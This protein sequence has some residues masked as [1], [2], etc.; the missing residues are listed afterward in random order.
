MA[1]RVLFG[2]AITTFSKEDAMMNTT[3]TTT[4][5]TTP[6]RELRNP[7][8]RRLE[9]LLEPLTGELYRAARARSSSAADADDLLQETYLR[10]TRS[11]RQ[12]R[13]GTNFRAW[14]FTILRS[15]AI[16]RFRRSRRLPTLVSQDV[17]AGNSA[18]PRDGGEVERYVDT[19]NEEHIEDLLG[20]DRLQAAFAEL[21]SRMRRVFLLAN[22]AG[23]KYE[24]I[25]EAMGCPLGTVRSRYSR[26]KERLRQNLQ[27][28]RGTRV[29]ERRRRTG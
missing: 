4:T 14:L 1:R 16:D 5:T 24:E 6:S 2:L 10:A 3:T 21:P 17:L 26:A 28:A 20:G 25:A 9:D 22:V 12:F 15:A 23:L 27:L 29:P 18:P 13:A 7:D 8:R 19:H 11:F